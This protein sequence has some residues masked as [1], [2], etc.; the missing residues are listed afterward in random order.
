MIV[1]W[2]VGPTSSEAGAT[3]D[4]FAGGSDVM[5]AMA[6]TNPASSRAIAV[7]TT[8]LGFPFAIRT[9]PLHNKTSV[10]HCQLGADA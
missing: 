8:C 3:A 4:V 6:Q 2:L 10:V 7:T 9:G 1:R 5:Q